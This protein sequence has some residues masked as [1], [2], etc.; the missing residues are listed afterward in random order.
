MHAKRLALPH[1]A[2]RSTP[3][4]RPQLLGDSLRAVAGS[5]DP[6]VGRG[7]YHEALKRLDDSND[8]VRL[9]G[10]A[11]LS[12]LAAAPQPPAAETWRGTPVEYA[13]DT[14]LLHL[15]DPAPAIQVRAGRE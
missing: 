6:D 9:A 12:A 1:I 2:A 8:A 15:D 14:L 7:L 5:L 10:C 13:V 4:P 11:A 3:L